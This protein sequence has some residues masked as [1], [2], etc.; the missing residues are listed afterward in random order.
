MKKAV[1]KARCIECQS[2]IGRHGSRGEDQE[3]SPTD[4]PEDSG[5][6][7]VGRLGWSK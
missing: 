2:N 7:K 6:T 1:G 3:G 5:S 4:E